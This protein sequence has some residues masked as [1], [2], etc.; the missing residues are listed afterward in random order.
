[1][2]EDCIIDKQPWYVIGQGN[3][4]A[5]EA[6]YCLYFFQ[7]YLVFQEANIGIVIDILLYTC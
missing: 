6:E 3:E 1:M 5:Y 4:Q 7:I 2:A